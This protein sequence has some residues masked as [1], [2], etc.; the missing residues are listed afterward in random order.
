MN[1]AGY[2]GAGA[3]LAPEQGLALPQRRWA[4]QPKRD[5]AYAE[6]LTDDGGIVT[7]VITRSG[8][9]HNAVDVA[10]LVG[11]HVGLPVARIIGELEAHTEAGLRARAARGWSCVHLFDLAA[12]ARASIAA[13][14]YA[15]RYAQLHRWQAAAECYGQVPRHVPMVPDRTTF[16]WSMPTDGAEPPRPTSRPLR[17]PGA[18]VPGTAPADLRRLPI[19]PMVRTRAQ[20]EQL[21]RTEVELGGGEGL[22][23]VRLDAPL[24]ARGG[25]R[26]IKATDTYDCTVVS[27]G[28]RHARL[29]YGGQVFAVSAKGKQLAAGD[30]VELACDG[31][32]EAGAT[33]RFPRIIRVRADLRASVNA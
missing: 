9:A 14:S 4:W 6:L 20:A 10:G 12:V 24:G 30:V 17:A 5:G 29:M 2:A 18:M 22:V 33:P 32:Y 8:E 7:D 13:W 28:P 11:L 16:L 21:W 3:R 31:W 26:K 27:V 15:D 23:A 19:V 25:K 1:A